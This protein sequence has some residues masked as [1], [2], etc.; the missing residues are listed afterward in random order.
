MTFKK[1]QTVTSVIYLLNVAKLRADYF[2][3]DHCFPP[4]TIV[5][6]CGPY[7]KDLKHMVESL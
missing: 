3:K 1:K 4:G 7:F 6:H 2:R 5:R